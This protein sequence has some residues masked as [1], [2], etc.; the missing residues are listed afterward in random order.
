M[1]HTT[2]HTVPFKRPF[3]PTLDTLSIALCDDSVFYFLNNE[4]RRVELQIKPTPEKTCPKEHNHD[5]CTQRTNHLSHR[6]QRSITWS[7]SWFGCR[8]RCTPLLGGVCDGLLCKRLK[9]WVHATQLTCFYRQTKIISSD[10]LAPHLLALL[11]SRHPSNYKLVGR[12]IVSL[13]TNSQRPSEHLG[14]QKNPSRHHLSVG[15]QHHN[16][17]RRHR[18]SLQNYHSLHPT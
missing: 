4:F 12:R 3:I 14:K 6:S 9:L 16:S 8:S 11:F 13:R 2:T 18:A 15:H 10:S 5:G 1:I 17:I 7:Y